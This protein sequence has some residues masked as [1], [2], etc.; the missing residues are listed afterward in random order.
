MVTNVYRCFIEWGRAGYEIPLSRSR[1]GRPAS[2]H[3]VVRMRNRLDRK[4]SNLVFFTFRKYRFT[5][6]F[7]CDSFAVDERYY[8]RALEY[9]RKNPHC[10]ESRTYKNSE[11]SYTYTCTRRP[12][13]DSKMATGFGNSRKTP[14]IIHGNRATPQR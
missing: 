12:S 7:H 4:T 1:L 10:S 2:G 13:G 6:F 3:T 14:T 8:G 5:L 9:Y 11:M